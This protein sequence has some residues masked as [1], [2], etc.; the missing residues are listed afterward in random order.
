MMKI[1]NKNVGVSID[2]EIPAEAKSKVSQNME[3]FLYEKEQENL[4]LEQEPEVADDQLI[5]DEVESNM[6]SFEALLDQKN[7]EHFEEDGDTIQHEEVKEKP[8]QQFI[9][10]CRMRQRRKQLIDRS[11]AIRGL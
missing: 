4:E 11:G 5:E 2:H 9:F 10:I 1:L 8:T 3:E 6:S 7:T